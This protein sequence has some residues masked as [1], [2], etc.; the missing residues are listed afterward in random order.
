MTDF[1]LNHNQLGRVCR[2]HYIAQHS[3]GR[4]RSWCH[5]LTLLLLE[6]TELSLFW[7]AGSN[8]SDLKDNISKAC[9]FAKEMG[10]ASVL[11]NAL[12]VQ[13][14]VLT[15][16]STND[17]SLRDDELEI[18]IRENDN[19][20]QTIVL[21]VLY[22]LYVQ[23]IHTSYSCFANIQIVHFTNYTEHSF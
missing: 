19:P 12:I 3:Y 10:N 2:R 11:L 8:L 5:P 9:K 4:V 6:L 14:T 16:M 13:K 1:C 17:G 7:Y 22:A 15:L 20:R 21:W 23:K 18:S